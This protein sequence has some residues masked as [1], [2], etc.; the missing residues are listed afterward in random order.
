M[1]YSKSI[2][3]KIDRCT[4]KNCASELEIDD[5]INRLEVGTRASYNVIKFN[6][7]DKSNSLRKS[8]S[9]IDSTSLQYD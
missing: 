5:F 2:A 1:N 8:L 6:T 7:D 9:D 4:G 3:F